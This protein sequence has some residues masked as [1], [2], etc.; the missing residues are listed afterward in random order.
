MIEVD[1]NRVIDELCALVAQQAKQIAILKTQIAQLQTAQ[2]G[3][4]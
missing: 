2:D 3:G 1:A 4:Q